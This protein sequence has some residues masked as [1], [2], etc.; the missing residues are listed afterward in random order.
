MFILYSKF[1]TF[2]QV[3][4]LLST[5]LLH[6]RVLGKAFYLV[7]FFGLDIGKRIFFFGQARRVVFRVYVNNSILFKVD[8]FT[9]YQREVCKLS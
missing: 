2:G 5:A 3:F 8:I 9:W 7:L 4:F 1:I 6:V